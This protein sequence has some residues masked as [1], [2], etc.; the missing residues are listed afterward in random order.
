MSKNKG[1]VVHTHSKN[2][3]SHVVGIG[4]LR[5]IVTNNDGSWFAQG[6]EIDYAA[7]GKSLKDVQNRFAEGLSATIHENLR[8][9]GSLENLIRPAPRDVWRG[10][11]EA[12]CERF[13]HEQVTTHEFKLAQTGATK[14]EPMPFPFAGI[15]YFEQ[16]PSL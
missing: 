3:M 4:N 9:F 6:L 1:G 7:E 11:L 2:S 15:D 8:R 5:V 14:Q 12:A 13:H 16:R 10:F